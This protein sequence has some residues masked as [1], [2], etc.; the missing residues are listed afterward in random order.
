[1]ICLWSIDEDLL[2]FYPIVFHNKWYQIWCCN[3]MIDLN[4]YWVITDL[5][6]D[7]CMKI[8]PIKSIVGDVEVIQHVVLMWANNDMVHWILMHKKIY[9]QG[10]TYQVKKRLRLYFMVPS[11]LLVHSWYIDEHCFCVLSLCIP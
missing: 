9:A 1:M 8:S 5:V 11:Y 4:K 7:P 6:V 3:L 10:E 2:E